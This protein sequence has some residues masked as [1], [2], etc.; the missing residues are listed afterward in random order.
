MAAPLSPDLSDARRHCEGAWPEEGVCAFVNGPHAWRF[1]PL[2]NVAQAAHEA[3]PKAF[4][5]SGRTSFLV[6][7]LE[8]MALERE[9]VGREVCLVH[10]HVDGP[11]TLSA[12][13]LS[14]FTID[15][16]PLLPHL[17]LVVLSVRDSRVVAEG[18]WR[19]VCG[20]W[21]AAL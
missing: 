2:R 8:W 17:S 7:P 19:F 6:E 1:V 20:G 21:A 13:D 9:A 12:W 10:S 18:R 3:D 5:R 15:G 14:T 4:P 16:H 11:A